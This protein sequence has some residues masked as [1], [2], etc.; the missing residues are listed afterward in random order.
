MRKPKGPICCGIE[1]TVLFVQMGNPNAFTAHCKCERKMW[2]YLG[3][4]HN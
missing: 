1:M 2:Y 3:G 4:W